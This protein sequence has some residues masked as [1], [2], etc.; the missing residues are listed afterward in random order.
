MLKMKKIVLVLVVILSLTGC[1]FRSQNGEMVI[2]PEGFTFEQTNQ[3][4]R[5]IH[6]KEFKESIY[7]M[8]PEWSS[9]TKGGFLYQTVKTKSLIGNG[10]GVGVIIKI[11][12][13]DDW[14]Q[15]DRF[16]QY[17]LSY[18]KSE[19]NKLEIK[20]RFGKT[21]TF[22][23]KTSSGEII[24]SVRYG[25]NKP[26]ILRLG[27]GKEVQVLSTGR[28]TFENGD[29]PALVL[30]YE[31]EIDLSDYIELKSEVDE[32]W[33]IF[34]QNVEESGY[35]TAA[36]RAQITIKGKG[37]KGYGFVFKKQPNGS[38]KHLE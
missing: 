18:L 5:D 20:N 8:F 36:V 7:S 37:V 12:D 34:R 13:L 2:M 30:R 31:T 11:Y 38:W 32:I 6:T 14:N 1:Q 27:N 22:I 3:F 26:K 23:E 29:P 21:T 35:T 33:K 16:E 28:Y 4:L 10:S 24:R 9:L 15:K 19:V 25:N 17:L